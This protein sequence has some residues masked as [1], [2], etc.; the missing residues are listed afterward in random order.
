MSRPDSAF[1]T[2]VLF[3]L[4]VKWDTTCRTAYTNGTV[5]GFNP[6][7]FMSLSPEE[8]VFL[9]IH[10]AMHVA[11]LHTVRLMDRIHAKF[12]V[13]ADHVINLSLIDRG[14]QMPKIGLA[15]PQYAGMCTEEVYNLLPDQDESKCDLD[16]Q[17]GD[18]SQ[19]DA[20]NAV[21]AIL[22]RA[23]IQSQMQGDRPGTIP[24]E[25]EI[26]LNKLLEPTL[27]WN[28]ILQ[29]YLHNFAKNDYSFRKP[30]RRFFPKHILPSLH[31]ESLINIAI[32]VD[33]SGSVRDEEFN[34]F[35][36]EIAG[37]FK[38]MKP[39]KI[40]LIT[41]DTT[42]KNVDQIKSLK[43]LSKVKFT[44][45]GGT[46]I[47]PV[48]DWAIENKPQL[49]LVFTDG[50]FNHYEEKTETPVIWLIHGG[51]PFQPPYGKVINYEIKT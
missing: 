38:M 48:I 13:A 51:R 10:E 12:N 6:T 32:A 2:T 30:N 8:R 50:C 14:F 42:I 11:Y 9:L 3:S 7:F 36:S 17:P 5:I 34:V 15:D 22:V 39:E 40:S 19:E 31:S 43:E 49:L 46:R 1:F 25:I 44:G 18:D 37:I 21:Q 16:I 24:S 28:R 23:A 33:A 41:F 20:E 35:I 27:P 29:K 26:F 45:R 4:K 47:K